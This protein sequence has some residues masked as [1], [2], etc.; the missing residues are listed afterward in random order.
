MQDTV[1]IRASQYA[2]DFAQELNKTNAEYISSSTVLRHL[3]DMG[4]ELAEP[5]IA[6]FYGKVTITLIWDVQTDRGVY[7]R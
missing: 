5:L 4:R 3:G 6:D 7:A 1:V 2:E